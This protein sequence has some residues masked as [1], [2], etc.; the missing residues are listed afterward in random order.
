MIGAVVVVLLLV[1][2]I[3]AL[4]DGG[5][6]RSDSGATPDDTARPNDVGATWV[7]QD[8]DLRPELDEPD[9]VGELDGSFDGNYLV[10][11]GPAWLAMTGD[12]AGGDIALH[13]LDPESGEEV[14][15]R[16]LDGGLCAPDPLPDGLVFCASALQRDRATDLG[17][18]WRLHLLDPATGQDARTADVEAWASA[19]HVA[20]ETLMVLEERE[21]SPHAVVS[22]F[23]A[24]L[25]PRW[26]LDLVGRE[27][28]DDLFSDDRIIG[29]PGPG[30]E[31]DG[32]IM[33][34][35]RF[36]DVG[37][38]G[39]TVAIWAGMATA[40]VDPASGELLGLPWCSRLV[41]D[42]ERL[43]CNEPD[44][45][46]AYSYGLDELHRV[47]RIRLL[48]PG[49]DGGA[50]TD[51]TRPVFADEDGRVFSVDRGTGHVN[52][53]FADLGTGSAFGQ[54]IEPSVSTSK[55]HTFISGEN[56]LAL[57][58]PGSDEL[59]WFNRE[60]DNVDAPIVREDDLLAGTFEFRLLSLSDGRERHVLRQPY[61]IYTVPVGEEIAGVGLDELALLDIP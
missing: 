46:V 27:H 59:A 20:G 50:A 41:D 7:V 30:V 36:R 32:P 45:A 54:T 19:V 29:R 11:A 17:T 28:H 26:S 40:F 52:G 2:A 43:W 12:E 38:R 18:R 16:E 58:T 48:F 57:L 55:G 24:Q 23:T 15:R 56:G 34:R 9:F 47:E 51:V 35:T 60:V 33:D 25:E 22:G 13:G 53:P 21:P 5:E 14:W 49:T 10:D 3:S 37:P 44:G 39:R 31:R 1:R 42:G 8:A 4:S 61:G 6:S